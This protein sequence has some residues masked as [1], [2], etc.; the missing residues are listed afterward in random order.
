MDVKDLRNK[1]KALYT[2]Y[3][4]LDQSSADNN[5]KKKYQQVWFR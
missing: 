3:A 5:S 4:M 1:Q 2:W